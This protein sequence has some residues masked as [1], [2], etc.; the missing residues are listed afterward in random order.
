MKIEKLSPGMTV[1]SV[2][3][4]KMGNTTISTVAVWPV[5]IIEVDVEQGT[6]IASWNCNAARKFYKPEWSKWRLKKPKLVQGPF[7]SHRLARR[8]G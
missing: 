4:H 6:V 7:G 5:E 8:G 3:R 2:G 1:Y